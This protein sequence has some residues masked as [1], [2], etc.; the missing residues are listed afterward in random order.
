MIQYFQDLAQL[1]R[2]KTL[3]VFGIERDF[4]TLVSDGDIEKAIQLMDD[5][6]DDVDL[7]INEY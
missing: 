7:C 5:N 4:L 3:N 6:E 1:F 2:N